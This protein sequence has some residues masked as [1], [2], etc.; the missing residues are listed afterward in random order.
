M[1]TP[2]LIVAP[3]TPFNEKLEVDVK[4]LQR[5]IDYIVN[6]CKAT[7]IVAGFWE[8]YFDLEGML[9]QLEEIVKK[10][11]VVDAN[12]GCDGL[13]NPKDCTKIYVTGFPVLYGY[14]LSMKKPMMWVLFASIA[15]M[16]AILWFEFRSWQGVVIPIVS[17]ALSA[18]WGLGFGGLWGYHLDP[19]VLVVP[20]LLSAR[21][22]AGAV[23]DSA[24]L[25]AGL[26]MLP[27]L[28]LLPSAPPGCSG[29]VAADVLHDPAGLRMRG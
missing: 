15:T 10:E 25:L 16:I 24:R 9:K 17:G 22:H 8:E 13:P 6:D 7:M 19:L 29:H 4:S 27:A 23:D 18:I 26:L 2:E 20:L 1:A 14:F 11:Q 5:Q 28:A 3:L 12:G 21:A